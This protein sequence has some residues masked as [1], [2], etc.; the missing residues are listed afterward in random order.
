M[1]TNSSVSVVMPSL[2]EERAIGIMIEE[3]KKYS[4]AFATEI[5]VVDSSTDRTPLI[6]QEMGARVIRQARSAHGAALRSGLRAATH[7]IIIT[8]DCDMTYPMEYIPLLVNLMRTGEYDLI[9]CNRMTGARAQKMPYANKL[10]NRAFALLVRRLYGMRVRDV[11]T[12]MFCMSQKVNRSITW[13]N[14]YTVPVEIIIK[15]HLAGFRHT[16]IDI[17]YRPR[18]GE[19]K[20][21]KWRAGVAVLLCIVNYRFKL[22]IKPPRI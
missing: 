18:I 8:T 1:S 7:D 16:E 3:I 12:G 9:S 21:P 13:E 2:N 19:I 17:P 20:L 22:N 6:A 10:A 15:T 14:Y 4:A 5:I 11:T